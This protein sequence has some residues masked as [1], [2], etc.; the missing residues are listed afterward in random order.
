MTIS[1]TCTQNII[2]SWSSGNS[3]NI[4][5]KM[6]NIIIHLAE[7]RHVILQNEYKVVHQN[8]DSKVFIFRL[9]IKDASWLTCGV[10]RL[11]KPN[12]SIEL[13][14]N[15]RN[16]VWVITRWELTHDKTLTFRRTDIMLTWAKTKSDSNGAWSNSFWKAL[17]V[18]LR[19]LDRG[20]LAIQ[21]LATV[22]E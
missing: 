22:V 9:D 21:K 12:F 7:Y 14:D 16:L 15:G 17:H 5:F 8:C 6:A 19:S 20:H 13:I 3:S 1:A 4:R 10:K 18:G 11:P 2:S